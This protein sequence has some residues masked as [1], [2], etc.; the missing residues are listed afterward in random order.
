MREE[1][2]RSFYGNMRKVGGCLFGIGY[3]GMLYERE[4]CRTEGAFGISRLRGNINGWVGEKV[5]IHA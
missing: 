2:E 3:F 4:V 5:D 1:K